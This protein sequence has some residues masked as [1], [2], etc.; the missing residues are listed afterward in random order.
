MLVFGPISRTPAL[1]KGLVGKI[2]ILPKVV[3]M[4]PVLFSV[5][6]LIENTCPAVEARIVPWLFSVADELVVNVP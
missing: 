5:V 1:E 6:G 4:V 3:A 2:P